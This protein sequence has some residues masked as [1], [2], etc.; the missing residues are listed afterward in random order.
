MFPSSLLWLALAALAAPADPPPEG[1]EP[2][3]QVQPTPEDDAAPASD[4]DVPQPAP[5]IEDP[6][7]VEPKALTLDEMRS[8]FDTMRRDLDAQAEA[9]RKQS[10]ELQAQ[11]KDLAAA[12]LSLVGK[13]DFKVDITGYYRT[14]GH[15]FGAK[16]GENRPTTGG[17][18]NDQPTSGRFINHRLRMGF[19]LK[20]KELASVHIHAQAFNNTL[21][22]DNAGIASAPLFAEQP[23]NTLLSGQTI[24][25]FEV[26][27]AWTEFRVPV[28]VVRVGR[29]SSHWGLGLL[30]N[31]G[32][33]FRND[34]GEA[35]FGNEFDRVLFGTNP[36]SLVQAMMGKQNAKEVPLTFAVAVDRLVEGPLDRY[37][38][39]RCSR[40]ISQE[41]DPE[42]Y[43][44]RCDTNGDGTTDQSHG[45]IEEIEESQRSQSWWADQRRDVWEMVYAL[46]YRGE[47]IR[48]LGGVG[49]LTAGGYLIHRL[50]DETDSNVLVGDI[51]IDAK[52][53][54]VRFQGEGLG[55]W[56]RTRA[57][58][59]P[60]NQN[61]DD[62]LFKRAAIYGYA[63]RLSYEQPLW[64]VLFESGAA[65]GDTNVNDEM[66]TGRPASPD[67]NVGLLLYQ[68]VIGRVTERMWGAGARGLR[69]RGGIY[70]SHYINPRIYVNPLPNTTII[71]AFLWATPDRPDGAVIRCTQR[72]VEKLGCSNASAEANALGWEIDLAIKH[73]FHK[74]ILVSMETGYAKATDRLP[75][76]VVGLN[77]TG[78]FWTFQTRV[79]YQ[80]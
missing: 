41:A 1:S 26:F 64:K 74:H 8:A 59:L 10:E 55:I 38:G 36:V 68:E 72:D 69:S 13:N 48:Y 21:W 16:W 56:G 63:A 27:R 44:P 52:V 45:F 39:Y 3:H 73:Q 25:S 40:G 22:G 80:F 37:Y 78:N 19:A 5:P 71:G 79:A 9:L 23:S 49:D 43:D 62:P 31:D 70:N 6:A 57:L 24:P 58:S 51:Y 18:F 28:G 20:Y 76:E 15:V 65:T 54:G 60:N 11:R 66:F 14:R 75:L 42:R 47:G 61:P 50:Q 33:G 30:A 77:P 67:Y 34:F 12:R 2:T 29:Q 7:E 53:H 35:Y 4:A 46:I 32:D 17:L